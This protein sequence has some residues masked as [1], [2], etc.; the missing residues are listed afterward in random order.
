EDR[1]QVIVSQGQSP[2]RGGFTLF[3]ILNQVLD[4]KGMEM[5]S[6]KKGMS[7]RVCKADHLHRQLHANRLSHFLPS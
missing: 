1:G 5:G 6:G 3:P 4:F 7:I 2:S